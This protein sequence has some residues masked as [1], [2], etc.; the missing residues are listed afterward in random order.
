MGFVFDVQSNT[1]LAQGGSYE[2]M[3]EKVRCGSVL[4][5]NTDVGV[6]MGYVKSANALAF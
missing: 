6:Y 1:V 3:K 5:Q 2:N 4:A